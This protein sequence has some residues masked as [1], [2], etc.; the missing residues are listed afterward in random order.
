M[1]AAVPQC[2]LAAQGKRDYDASSFKSRT[3]VLKGNCLYYLKDD[4]SEVPAGTVL[5]DGANIAL[6]DRSNDQFEIITPSR[7][8][9]FKVRRV[10]A[11]SVGHLRRPPPLADAVGHVQPHCGIATLL[12]RTVCAGVI[13]RRLPI[14]DRGSA[15]GR[16]Y[17]IR[18]EQGRAGPADV[19]APLSA[20]AR[21]AHKAG[22]IRKDMEAAVRDPR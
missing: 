21:L 12:H 10:S 16:R 18:A 13:A 22:R 6:S 3:C 7:T 11:T 9:Y 2:S 4:T 8:F 17:N 19:V 14:V 20:K 1:L 15:F 5:L